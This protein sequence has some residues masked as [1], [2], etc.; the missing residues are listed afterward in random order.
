[1]A[2]TP[3][4]RVPG[5]PAGGSKP[6]D[7]TTV[8]SETT[9]LVR[10]AKSGDANRAWTP[11]SDKIVYYLR[12]RFGNAGF[13]PGTEFD[14][15]VSDMMARVMTS[16]GSFEDRGNQSFWR[17]VQ[18]IG[19]NLWRDMW[20]RFERDRRLGI[21]GRGEVRGDDEDSAIGHAV[22]AAPVVGD[23]PTGIVRVRELERAE[24]EC[25]ARLPKALREVYI[26]RRVHEMSFA[27]ISAH[28]GVRNHATLRSHYMRARDSVREC[29]ARRIDELGRTLTGWR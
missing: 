20:R 19:G 3:D 26:Q 22:D 13:P 11:L 4:G 17:W 9:N 29:L 7:E 1:M 18:T 27:E 12:T 25:V 16:I 28:G 14:D 6:A 8:G 2:R 23:S 10:Q 5:E 15:F 24:Q 21:A